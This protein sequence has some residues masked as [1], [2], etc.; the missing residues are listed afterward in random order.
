MLASSARSQ[1]EKSAIAKIQELKE[2]YNTSS[3]TD[4]GQDFQLPNCSNAWELGNMLDL[5]EA[6]ATCALNRQESRGGHARE[7]F[8]QRDDVNWLK[9]TL[10]KIVGAFD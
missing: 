7:D 1:H 8:P 4:T 10:A 3:W 2:R 6:I 5:A 9:H